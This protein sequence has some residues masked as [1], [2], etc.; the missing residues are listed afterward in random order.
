VSQSYL[1]D[2]NILLWSWHEPRRVPKRLVEVL[3]GEGTFY[4]SLISI[5]E[6]NIKVSIGKLETVSR[7]A[8]A[9]RATRYQILPVTEDHVEAVRHLPLHHRDPYDRI[10]IAQA[11]S[12]N[13]VVLTSDRDFARYDIVLA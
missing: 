11:M 6:I 9:V 5:W 8:D 4:V 7:V 1:V 13:L 2:T 3:E 12:E 10:L